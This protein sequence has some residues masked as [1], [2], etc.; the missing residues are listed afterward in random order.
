MSESFSIP[1]AHS[2][3]KLG[4]LIALVFIALV[5]IVAGW[6]GYMLWQQS[7]LAN[8]LKIMAE[9]DVKLVQ[10]ST[11]LLEAAYGRHQ[12]LL[13]Q[14]LTKDPFERDAARQRYDAWGNRVGRAR[15]LLAEAGLDA[16]GKAN[17]ARQSAMIPRIVALQEQVADLAAAEQLD[18]A[19]DIVSSELIQLD[20]SFDVLVQDLR[21]HERRKVVVY[22]AEAEAVA[23]KM[24][25]V[26]LILGLAVTLLVVWLGLFVSRVMAQR[27]RAISSQ[28]KQ[29]ETVG[30]KL[31][32]DATYDV[33]TGLA[34]RRLFFQKLH[35][36]IALSKRQGVNVGV[37]YMDLDQFKPINDRYGHAVGDEL[38]KVV[39]HRL[40]SQLRGIDTIARLGG[41]EFA[42]VL[43]HTSEDAI[44]KLMLE[45]RK[46]VCQPVEFPG[47]VVITPGISIGYALC[48]RD[49]DDVDALLNHADAAM[50]SNKIE[51]S[52]PAANE[53]R[54]ARSL[55]PDAGAAE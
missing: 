43:M 3:D 53:G 41:D 48:P 37:A 22:A 49:A 32:H 1:L 51:R 46:S 52:G 36:A 31:I 28:A 20:A 4:R 33:L 35:Q 13:Q 21:Q 19:M 54:P 9:R 44:R 10:V 29:L 15:R 47:G 12:S 18:Q 42:L 30:Q 8:T 23:A 55:R 7:R 2:T 6:T 27:G 24:Y 50:Y 45:M 11:D 25:Q 16:V 5:L 34:N 38:L 39:A 26:S 40:Q 14:V 17:L